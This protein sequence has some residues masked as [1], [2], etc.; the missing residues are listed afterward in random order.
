MNEADLGEMH[1]SIA[2]AYL[3][4]EEFQMDQVRIKEEVKEQNDLLKLV[5]VSLSR[6]PFLRK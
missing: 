5:V 4:P 6:R 2:I 3:Q 1:C